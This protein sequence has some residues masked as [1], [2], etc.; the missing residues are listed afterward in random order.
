MNRDQDME[1]SNVWKTVLQ[2]ILVLLRANIT[3]SQ[4]VVESINVN[5]A[6]SCQFTHNGDIGVPDVFSKNM[7]TLCTLWSYY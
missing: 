7:H 5:V 4:V 1:V 3:I 6:R 2:V